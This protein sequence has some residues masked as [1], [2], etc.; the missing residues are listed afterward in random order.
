VLCFC[1]AS[2]GARHPAGGSLDSPFG[3]AAFVP[4]GLHMTAARLPAVRTG[5]TLNHG[6]VA[7]AAA[8]YADPRESVAR[9]GSFPAGSPVNGNSPQPSSSAGTMGQ[10][11][12]QRSFSCFCFYCFNRGKIAKTFKGVS[13]EVVLF[14]SFFLL[15]GSSVL[16]LDNYAAK[17][18]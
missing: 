17:R 12:N 10:W 18:G 7:A 6:A 3:S 5:A 14:L 2:L 11:Y 13:T 15:V 16:T 8:Y 1:R 4:P 9:P